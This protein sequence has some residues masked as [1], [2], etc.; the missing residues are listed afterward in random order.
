MGAFCSYRQRGVT[1]L[2]VMI[3][4]VVIG[5]MVAIAIPSLRAWLPK[6]QLL[7][8]KRNLVATMQ[9]ARIKAVASGHLCYMEFLGS[10]R[11]TCF[12][13]T[14]DDANGDSDNQD[15]SVPAALRREYAATEVAFNAL[16]A[17][18]PVIRLPGLI[19]F[20]TSATRDVNGSGS[21]PD[22]GFSFSGKPPCAIF[23]P[24]GRGKMGTVYLHYNYGESY[25]ISVN[26]VGRIL[27]RRWDPTGR[28]WHVM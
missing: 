27:V 28:K 26:I 20:G 9:L 15:S 21:P 17:G 4:V 23:Y 22:N 7:G 24:S 12:L 16:D 8:A 6:Y 3:V 1:L 19:R 25:A 2:E 18:I 11:Y 14:D 10:D 5:I 13:D